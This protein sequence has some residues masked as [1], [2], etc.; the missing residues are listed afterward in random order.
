MWQQLLI[1]FRPPSAFIIR[2]EPAPVGL[3]KLSA[4]EL[5]KPARRRAIRRTPVGAG[6]IPSIVLIDESVIARHNRLTGGA[7]PPKQERTRMNIKVGKKA[8]AEAT[9]KLK[10]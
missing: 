7:E 1:S 4:T 9:E 6:T 3:R 5:S 2:S 10:N 8:N